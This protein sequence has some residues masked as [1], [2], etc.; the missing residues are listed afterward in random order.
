MML[1]GDLE[2]SETVAAAAGRVEMIVMDVDGVLTDGCTYQLDNGEQ[3]LRFSVQ[4]AMGLTLC[5]VAGIGLAVISGRDVPAARIRMSRF[6]VAEMHFG[7][8]HKIPV[9]EAII[10][11]QGISPERMAY[12]GDDLIDLPL[13][14]RVGLPV[15]VANAMPEVA[16]AALYCTRKAGGQGAVRELID[17]VLKARGVYQETVDEYLRRH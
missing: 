5:G 3:F 13:M 17:L 2:V 9:L 4:D 8:V 10:D 11:R 15:A 12:I 7:C 6:P 16:A 1:Y 14:T